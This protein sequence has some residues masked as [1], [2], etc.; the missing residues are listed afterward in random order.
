MIFPKRV[1]HTYLSIDNAQ[2]HGVKTG[3]KFAIVVSPF[4]Y[5]KDLHD[6]VRARISELNRQAAGAQREDYLL[7][8]PG[9]LGSRKRDWG[10]DAA[11]KD[12]DHASAIFEYGVD[13]AGREE[14]L[15]E[16]ESLT[17]G[18]YGSHFL[19]MIQGGYDEDRKR[20]QTRMYGTQGT[21]FLTNLMS[22]NIIYGYIPPAPD[23]LD[24]WFF[25]SPDQPDAVSVLAFPKPVTIYADSLAQRCQVVLGHADPRAPE[26]PFRPRVIN[27]VKIRAG[28]L[29]RRF[30]EPGSP[31]HPDEFM[32]WF[33]PRS[34]ETP[35]PSRVPRSGRLPFDDTGLKLCD[36]D[37]LRRNNPQA[38]VALLT[39]IP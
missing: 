22:G 25:S 11:Y 35:G 39:R 33:E 32:P 26:R 20:L 23:S 8:V 15:P 3:I 7:I 16:D 30:R 1:R 2:G 10:I 27:P 24:P 29:F 14:P 9:R 4:L 18:I 28:G 13:I 21:H 36:K 5:A 19:Y 6:R 17:G 37:R 31:A 34:W 38:V 12:V